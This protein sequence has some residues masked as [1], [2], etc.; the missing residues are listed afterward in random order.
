MRALRIRPVGCRAGAWPAVLALGVLLLTLSSACTAGA[1]GEARGVGD[2]GDRSTQAGAAA[3]AKTLFVPLR[4]YVGDEVEAIVSLVG[5]SGSNFVAGGAS[6]GG[7]ELRPGS[8]LPNP[9]PH[10]NPV[11]RSV[12]IERSSRG[13]EA[14]LTF[15]P[16]SP[17]PGAIPAISAKG[18]SIP[19]VAYNVSS[20]LGPEEGELAPPRPQREPPGTAIYLYGFAGLVLAIILGAL[21]TAAYL[22]PAAR[23]LLARWRAAQAFRRLRRGLEYLLRGLESADPRLFYAALARELRIY[24]AERIEARIPT[25]SASEIA[26][27]PDSLFPAP[28]LRESAAALIAETEYGRYSGEL[29]PGPGA[30]PRLR[31][32]AERARRLGES[33]EEAIDARL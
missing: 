23:V 10:A 18:F 2:V 12:K 5:S 22:I 32:A 17:G 7:V 31:A 8:G 6:G 1:S 14:R 4:Y 20:V 33:A 16:W 28:G 30:V 19:P 11:L 15:V 27:L 29:R 25:L 21:G 24:L 9:G 3:P 13:W 26:G